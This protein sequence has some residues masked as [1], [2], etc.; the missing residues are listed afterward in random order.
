MFPGA[1]GRG[2]IEEPK[3]QLQVVVT[4]SGISFTTHD[5][6]RTFLTVAD[7]LDLSPY[8]IK[9]LANHSIRGDVTAGYIIS[10]TERL[11]TAMERIEQFLL[12]AL[13]VDPGAKVI[14]LSDREPQSSQS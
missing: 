8:T 9:R 14:P 3:R 1:G 7:A 2:H 11:R 6:R 13:E 12:S 4:N 5:L 10:D